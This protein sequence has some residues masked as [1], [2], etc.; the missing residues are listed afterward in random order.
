M[1]LA[2][3]TST[4]YAGVALY[5]E[6]GVLASTVWRS[7]RM[8]TVQ[9]LPTV[10][11]LLTRAGLSPA[12]LT[13]IAVA[14]GPGSFTG[15]RVGL[16]TAKGLSASLGLPLVGVSTLEY[17]AQPQRHRGLPVY[18][19]AR[20]GRGRTAVGRYTEC[21]SAAQTE[22][23][24]RNLTDADFGEL[25]AGVYC[26]ELSDAVREVLNDV[27]GAV[28]VPAVEGARNPAVLACLGWERLTRGEADPAAALQ[29]VYLGSVNQ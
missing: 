1:L 28:V 11:A 8:H 3:D 25:G 19:C 17:T 2:L 26:G 16:A 6:E 29:A 27:A 12:D 4:E 7:V 18:A 21:G 24:V 20:L 13:G 5:G 15:V 10:D 23:W 9:L 22:E 14:L